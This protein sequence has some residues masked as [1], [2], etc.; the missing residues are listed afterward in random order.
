MACLVAAI[1]HSCK[2]QGRNEAEAETVV[3]VQRRVVVAVRRAAV[4][5]IPA[6][7]AAAVHAVVALTAY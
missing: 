3:T 1:R 4:L 5:R 6:P 7:V 2:L